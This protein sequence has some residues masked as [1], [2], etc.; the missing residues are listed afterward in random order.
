M[1]LRTMFRHN[2]DHINEQWA[3]RL[4]RQPTLRWLCWGANLVLGVLVLPPAF[5]Y[6]RL[7]G[8]A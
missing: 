2:I 7:A 8:R 1:T 5:A 6:M 3:L 4:P